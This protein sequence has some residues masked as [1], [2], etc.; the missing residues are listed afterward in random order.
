MKKADLIGRALEE[1]PT[2]ALILDLD[3]V[4]ANLRTAQKAAKKVGIHV[5]PHAKGHK[6][7]E[8]ARKQIAYGGRG[9]CCTKLG[10]AEIFANSG[11]ENILLTSEL[12]DENK[13][14]RACELANQV[15]LILVV[16]SEE[17]IRRLNIAA[18]NAGTKIGV[19][20]ELN[21]GQNRCG[22]GSPE[23]ARQLAHQ[24]ETAKYLELRGIQAYHGRLQHVS[25]W[26][27]R[28]DAVRSAMEKVDHVIDGF[29]RDGL[30]LEI[31]TGG[32]TGTFETDCELGR[33][34]EV[35]PGSYVVMDAQYKVI[36]GQAGAFQVFQH[37]LFVRTQVISR[38]GDRWCVVDAGLK[39]MSSDAGHPE[40][41]E[42]DM[43]SYSFA[44]DEHG[45]IDL[46]DSRP[47]PKI[48]DK[49]TIIPG[50]CDTTINLYDHYI[51]VQ[52]GKVVDV[53]SI[54]TRGRIQ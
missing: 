12:V 35:Q 18:S 20:I 22:V 39:S 36:G 17:G 4:E 15:E 2:P 43:L 14:V 13:L 10:E 48:G 16:D 46:K 42:Y 41:I 49:L 25:G 7:V 19:L 40:L 8:I 52:A 28:R 38:T 6:S 34:N 51:V 50:H 24:V 31:I 29:K 5:R 33:L 30:S 9:I 27:A 26:G 11:I 1:V 47:G 44:G 45:I 23:E 54:D 21:V 37:A 53:W 3:A 32:G